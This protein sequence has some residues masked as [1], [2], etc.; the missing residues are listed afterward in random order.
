LIG[1]LAGFLATLKG[2]PLA[3]NRDLQEDKEPLFD[4][5]DACCARRWPSA[6]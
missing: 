4:A 1:H 5:L 2:L 6:G 3:H